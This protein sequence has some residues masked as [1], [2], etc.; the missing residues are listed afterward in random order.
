MRNQPDYLKRNGYYPSYFEHDTTM[1]ESSNGYSPRGSEVVEKMSENFGWFNMYLHGAPDQLTVSAPGHNEAGSE[2]D[3]IVSVDSCEVYHNYR[4]PGSSR[5]ESGN[6]LDSLNNKDYYAIMFLNSCYSG[7]YDFEH[8]DLFNNYSSPS[9]AE[10]FTLLPECGGP[11]LLGYT[12]YGK[13]IASLVLHMRF[14]DIL[15]NDTVPN[16][17]GVVEAISK[18]KVFPHFIHLSH[19]LFGCPLMPVWTDKP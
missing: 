4:H 16:N 8:F 12:R 14:L 18:T 13:V 6:G 10:A 15:F 17:I 19:T 1:L 9:I 11:A 7:A 3:F 5:I 2:R